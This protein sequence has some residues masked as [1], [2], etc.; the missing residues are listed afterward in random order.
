MSTNK[1]LYNNKT[2]TYYTN[3]CNDIIS[4]IP[5][6]PHIILEI[7]CGK[8][9][10]LKKLKELGKAKEV[11]GIDMNADINHE[12]SGID[13]IILQDIESMN[14]LPFRKNYFDYIIFADVIEHFVDPWKVLKMVNVYLND[15]GSLMAIIPNLLH[16]SIIGPLLFHGSFKYDPEGGPLD[17]AHLR[18]FTKKSAQALFKSSGYSMIHFI[19]YPVSAKARI[20]NFLSFGLLKEFFI[21]KLRLIANK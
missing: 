8:G 3:I 11:V 18:F 7:G 1:N 10:T 13:K 14:S 21:Y 4:L 17:I 6:G 9:A 19:D 5:E 16:R 20:A 2:D 12:R 15:N